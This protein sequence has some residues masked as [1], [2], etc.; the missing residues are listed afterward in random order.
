VEERASPEEEQ[1]LATVWQERVR[2][3]LVD[4]ARDPAVFVVRPV[5]PRWEREKP[6]GLLLHPVNT[7]TRVAHQR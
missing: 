1:Q 3:L 7:I 2:H 5:E 4:L 6:R